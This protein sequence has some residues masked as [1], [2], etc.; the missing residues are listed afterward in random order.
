MFEKFI[1]HLSLKIKMLYLGDT[2]SLCVK[3]QVS[4]I[5]QTF[6]EKDFQEKPNFEFSLF[7]SNYLSWKQLRRIPTFIRKDTVIDMHADQYILTTKTYQHI[8]PLNEEI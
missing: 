5:K 7:F 4:L 6:R 2:I 8:T 1:S 3:L